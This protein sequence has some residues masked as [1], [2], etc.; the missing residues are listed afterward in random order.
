MKICIAILCV[1]GFYSGNAFG[2]VIT[3]SGFFVSETG[4]VITNAHVVAGLKNVR[5]RLD[6][7]ETVTATIEKIDVAN[8]LALLKASVVSSPL[9][10]LSSAEVEKGERV[11][12]IGFPRVMD[13]GFEAKYTEGSISS[14]S[15]QRGAQNRYQISTPIQSGNSGGPLLNENGQVVGIIVSKLVGKDVENVSYAIKSDYVIPLLIGIVGTNS[16]K[17]NN[18]KTVSE[19]EKSVVLVFGV[20]EKPQGVSTLQGVPAKPYTLDPKPNANRPQDAFGQ[21]LETIERL[22]QSI[23]VYETQSGD[24]HVGV[25]VFSDGLPVEFKNS[26]T[27]KVRSKL[28]EVVADYE[29]SHVKYG[30]SFE[31]LKIGVNSSVAS[32]SG[33]EIDAVLV[34][35]SNPAICGNAGC[36]TYIYRLI[37]SRWYE[38]GSLFG[39]TSVSVLK[40]QSKGMRDISYKG[41]RSGASYTFRYD[42]NGYVN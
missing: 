21:R 24:L 18:N 9:F 38:A 26:L 17:E 25:L 29:S 11:Y 20:N 36:T 14:F 10:I 7:G 6:S 15:G 22:F 34:E 30:G 23:P 8:D 35:F 19:V 1:V 40:S 12:T 13:Q 42:G 37:G 28:S 16:I 33:S 31:K 2:S 5:L 27:S 32:L 4:H 41:C 39:C 3:G